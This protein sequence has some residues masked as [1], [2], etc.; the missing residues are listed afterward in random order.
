MVHVFSLHA[1][2]IKKC[3]VSVAFSHT[4]LSVFTSTINAQGTCK[5]TATQ[6]RSARRFRACAR[7]RVWSMGG[8]G[9]GRE[10]ERARSAWMSPGRPFSV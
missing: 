5:A 1:N 3:P 8:V 6:L 2:W 7:V 9:A 4:W 10:R